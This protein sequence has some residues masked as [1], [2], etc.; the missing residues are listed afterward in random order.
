MMA[1]WHKIGHLYNDGN[2]CGN[3]IYEFFYPGTTTPVDWISVAT[4]VDF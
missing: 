2:Y 4:P 1:P 3:L